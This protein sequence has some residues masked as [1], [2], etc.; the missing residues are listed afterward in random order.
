MIH[1]NGKSQF[2]V[3]QNPDLVER[4]SLCGE[5]RSRQPQS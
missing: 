4:R 5:L 1:F 3:G 2:Y